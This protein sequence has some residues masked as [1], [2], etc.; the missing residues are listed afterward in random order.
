MWQEVTLLRDCVHERL[1]PLYGVAASVGCSCC[2]CPIGCTGRLMPS[3]SPGVGCRQVARTRTLKVP[4]YF[5]VRAKAAQHCLLPQAR[6][7]ANTNG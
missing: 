4:F 6:V 1:V 2:G 7:N 3:R 5:E